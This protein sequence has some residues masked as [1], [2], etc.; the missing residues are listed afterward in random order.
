M[1]LSGIK[2]A[3]SLGAITCLL[4]ARPVAAVPVGTGS[5]S[6]ECTAS[7][8]CGLFA[9]DNIT[10]NVFGNP[11]N[12]A[13]SVGGMT[14]VDT[15]I[16]FPPPGGTAGTYAGSLQSIPIPG[17]LSLDISGDFVCGLPDCAPGNVSFVGPVSVLAMTLPG[18]LSYTLDGTGQTVGTFP[19]ASIPSCSLVNVT[20]WSGIFA[21]DAFKPGLTPTGTNVIVSTSTTYYDSL[22][23]NQVPVAIDITYAHVTSAGET[24]V[25]SFSNGT[26]ELAANFVAQVDGQCAGSPSNACCSAADCPAGTDPCLD[27]YR[28]P[29]TDIKTT[30]VYTGPLE[31]C[32]HLPDANA[33]GIVDGTNVPTARL[34]MLHN[35]NGRF[36]DRTDSPY[37]LS[38]GVV[39]AQVESLSFFIITEQLANDRF[40]SPA[41]TDSGNDCLVSATP[42]MTIAYALTQAALGDTIK[43]AAG[44]YDDSSTVTVASSVTLSGGW[45]A[46]FA[47][48]DPAANVTTINDVSVSASVGQ[49]NDVIIDGFNIVP[50]PGDIS[51]GIGASTSGTLRLAINN[52]TLFASGVSASASGGVLNLEISD[53]ILQKYKGSGA[54][55][56]GSGGSSVMTATVSRCTISKSNSSSSPSS[57]GGAVKASA[58][59]NSTLHLHFSDSVVTKNKS[60]TDGAGM[61]VVGGGNATVDVSV[62]RCAFTKNKVRGKEGLGGGLLMEAFNA[63]DVTLDVVDSTVSGNKAGSGGGIFAQDAQVTVQNTLVAQNKARG[64]N[65]DGF[66][67]GG[68]IIFLSVSAAP[69]SLTLSSAT[70]THNTSQVAGGLVLKSF[71]AASGSG[72]F[73]NSIIWGNTASLDPTVDDLLFIEQTGSSLTATKDHSDIGPTLFTAGFIFNDLGGNIDADPLFV[74]K[75]DLHLTA[76]SPARDTGTCV[77]APVTDLD[78]DPRPTGPSCDMG[79]YEFVP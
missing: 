72:A 56:V 61:S 28:T 45:A 12:L 3:A 77:G 26:G 38:G 69:R 8:C 55:I 64:K 74:K 73:V 60:Y 32:A 16:G 71:A 47:S 67:F 70:V 21:L 31:I 29:Y 79:A 15:T 27:C 48:R 66:G 22:T 34:R 39:C 17:Q 41:G 13:T 1:T 52:S 42:C 62:A 11:T 7:A 53:S 18:G 5:F 50:F 78:G 63:T 24:S 20:R 33:D 23:G 35:E 75:K 58:G 59:D 68:G 14:T 6:V 54:L 19:T 49:T 65:A 44:T 40:V 57:T 51:G 76:A 43:V 36:V 37:V 4:L 2:A 46:D 25:T 30:A 10:Y 9:F